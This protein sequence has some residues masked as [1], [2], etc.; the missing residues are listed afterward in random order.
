MGVPAAIGN[1]ATSTLAG[2]GA[3]DL[4]GH[5]VE[6]IG[7]AIS[8]G[9]QKAQNPAQPEEGNDEIS[10]RFL[11][12]TLANQ[13]NETAPNSQFS[14]PEY[15][16]TY[17][18]EN[19]QLYLTKD[20][21]KILSQVSELLN[22]GSNLKEYDP[23]FADDVLHFAFDYYNRT[24]DVQGTIKKLADLT[25]KANDPNE[26][27]YVEAVLKKNFALASILTLMSSYGKFD[28]S[29]K[30]KMADAQK[31][32]TQMLGPQSHELLQAEALRNATARANFDIL[33]KSV[34]SFDTLLPL[35]IMKQQLLGAEAQALTTVIKS[36]FVKNMLSNPTLAGS[37]VFL[38]S[39][40][41]LGKNLYSNSIGTLSKGGSQ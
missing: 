13:F 32:A 38:Q 37:I 11:F 31:T 9:I 6:G 36:D 3:E 26:D 10:R 17:I 28:A 2:I 12:N 21:M 16:R 35:A 34:A 25:E 22:A 19:S 1:V 23:D 8:G 39:L 24:G 4:I 29:T 7:N 33:Q 15:L 40:P 18:G 27:E 41:A 20:Y 14:D 30:S 5:A